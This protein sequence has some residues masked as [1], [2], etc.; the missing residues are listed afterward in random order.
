[1]KRILVVEDYHALADIET[2]LCQ[3]EGYDVK[4]AQTGE[5]GLGLINSYKPD[6]VILDLMLPGELSG[7]QVLD[8]IREDGQDSPKVLVVSA[9]VNQTTAPELERHKNVQTLKK[10]FKVKELASRVRDMVGAD[11]G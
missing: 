1:M 10:P 5:E 9:L 2:L 11:D 4:S 3:M 7:S 6:L 8:K